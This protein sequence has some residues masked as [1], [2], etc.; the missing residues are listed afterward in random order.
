MDTTKY[1][2]FF[3]FLVLL[4]VT[5]MSEASKVP[6]KPPSYID[7]NCHSPG[8][9]LDRYSRASLYPPPS[10]IASSNHQTRSSKHGVALAPAVSELSGGG[11]GGYGH[12][13]NR[14]MGM[15]IAMVPSD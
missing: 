11:D 3:V 6:P 7:P 13:N 2:T 12:I 9:S 10:G 14:K 5:F 4:S 8:S 15:T 1:T